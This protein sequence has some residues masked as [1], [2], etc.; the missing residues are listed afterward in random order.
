[1]VNLNG[2]FSLDT[3]GLRYN[4]RIVVYITGKLIEKGQYVALEDFV[5]LSKNVFGCDRDYLFQRLVQAHSSNPEKMYDIL[6]SIEE[7]GHIPSKTLSSEIATILKQAG[8]NVPLNVN[9]N[10]NE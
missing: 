1:M 4:H 8:L 2:S 5:M 10:S 9:S 7:E 3:N 6:E